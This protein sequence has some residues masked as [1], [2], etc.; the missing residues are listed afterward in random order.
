VP[1]PPSPCCSIIPLPV[2]TSL[3]P[4]LAP[5]LSP[6]QGCWFGVKYSSR[7]RLTS[8]SL[9]SNVTF[10]CVVHSQVVRVWFCNRRQKGKRSSSDYSQ[11]EDFEAAGSPF[12]GAPV[13]FHLAPGLHFG[14][15]GY[16]SPHFTTLYSSVPFPEGEA[17]PPVS[18]TT[19]GSPM[20]SN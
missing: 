2:A 17:Y 3:S 7:A 4:A 9:W 12:S 19:L 1:R 11:R 6:L 18:V 10:L 20:H 15:P 5:V 8:L 14:T 13:S 16:G